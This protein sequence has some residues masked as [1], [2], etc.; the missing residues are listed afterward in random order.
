MN[1]SIIITR[2]HQVLG[3][4]LRTYNLQETY[5]DEAE[6]WV[7]ILAAADF[8]VRSTYHTTKGKSPGQ[9]V[10][11]RDMILPINQVAD[12]RYIL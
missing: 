10:F 2:I 8:A 1:G 7:G 12:W 11:V 5:I 9:L 6:P 3:N 4:L